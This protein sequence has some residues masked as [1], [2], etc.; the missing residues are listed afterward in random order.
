[1]TIEVMSPTRV[2]LAGGTLDCWP[3]H[4]F[5]GDCVTINLSIDI[6]THVKLT[7]KSDLKIEV[8]IK[9]FPYKKIFSNLE[10][11][12]NCEDKELILLKV[13]IKHWQP[14]SGF[15][16]ETSSMSPIGGGLGGSSSLSIGLIKAFCQWQ[17]RD[18]K[19]NE[20]VNLAHNLE[21]RMLNTPTGTQ[22][23]FPAAVHGL[24]AIYYKDSGYHLESLPFPEE[25]FKKKMFLV[26]TGVP[27]HSGINN[28]QVIKK[29]VS[30]DKSTMESLRE[31]SKISWDLESICR[32]G[33]WE[34]LTAIFN[35]EYQARV[36][37]S[38]SFASP[39]IEK[40]KEHVLRGGAEAV[41]ICGAGGG[42]CVMVWGPEDKKESLIELCQ[43]EKYQVLKAK[44]VVGQNL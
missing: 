11:L 33:K 36:K 28:W 17:K 12:I 29:A 35:R 1:M 10:E 41:K 43:K 24:N 34:Q 42:G 30:G 5:V 3:L 19:L 38:P 8:H 44:P 25:L 27:H 4:A 18:L 31:V 13:H 16:I 6:Y 22:D 20:M 21:A 39:A 7:P 26:Y 2:D 32:S 37:L 15:L 9:D 14:K 23:Y 40:L